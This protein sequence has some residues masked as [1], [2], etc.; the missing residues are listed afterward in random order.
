[1]EQNITNG[2]I[3]SKLVA[4]EGEIKVHK[5]NIRIINVVA[6]AI[7]MKVL[8]IVDALFQTGAGV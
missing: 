5:F 6:G 8:G 2:D 3:Y 4:I 7:G 1:M